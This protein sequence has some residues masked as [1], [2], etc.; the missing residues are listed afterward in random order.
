MFFHVAGE[1]R[2]SISES[3]PESFYLVIF[4][5]QDTSAKTISGRCRRG[6]LHL[7]NSTTDDGFMEYR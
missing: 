3:E 6:H 4:Q 5:T 1:L 7:Y 2:M